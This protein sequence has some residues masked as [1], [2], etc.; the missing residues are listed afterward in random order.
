MLKKHINIISPVYLLLVFFLCLFFLGERASAKVCWASAVIEVSSEYAK[1]QYS[2]NQALGMP[3]VL[4]S[5]GKSPSSWMPDYR[6]S[7]RQHWIQ[8][9]FDTLIKAKQIVINEN[10]HPGGIIKICFFSETG[11]KYEIYN[12]TNPSFLTDAKDY[13][14]LTF[15]QTEYNIASVQIILKPNPIFDGQ[16]IDAVAISDSE[17]RIIPEIYPHITGTERYEV[18]NLGDKVNS[19]YPDLAPLIS[20]DGKTLYFTRDKH[21][22]NIGVDKRQDIWYSKKDASGSFTA[23][24]NIGY[25]IN[26]GANNFALSITPDGNKM[27][28][29]NVYLPDGSM[30]KGVSFTTKEGNEWLPPQKVNIKNFYNLNKATGGFFLSNSGKV[31]IMSIERSDGFGGLDLYVSFPLD[32]NNFTEPMNLGRLVNTASD[33]DSPFLASD[34]QTLYFSTSGIPGYGSNDMFI[35][36]RQ[37]SSWTNWD[38]PKN[39]G[40]GINTSGWDAYYTIPAS[41]DYAYFVSDKKSIGMDDIFRIKLPDWARPKPVLLVSGVVYN[42]KTHKPIGSKIIYETLPEGKEVGVAHSNNLTGEYQIVLPAGKKYGFLAQSDGF[43]A[44]N[45]HLDL[46]DVSLYGEITR[47]LFLIPIEIGQTIRLNNIFFDFDKFDLLPDSYIELNRLV[48]FL[49]SNSALQIEIH[50]H[51]DNFGSNSYNKS[52]SYNR[53]NAVAN[54]LISKNISSS[55]L[56]VKG[57]GEEKPVAKNDTDDNRKLNRRV[58]FVIAGKDNK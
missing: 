55:R 40:R 38:T 32:S 6:I 14:I 25:P 23:A 37:D 49:N 31:M 30:S 33:E 47:D 16:Q 57:F 44:V 51:T 19:E 4:P 36:R 52:L 35:T 42:K 41:G 11:E 9:A 22:E 7:T 29:G 54:Y 2:A 5:F 8:L 12:N 18:Q 34:E 28:V 39:M 15:P 13:F 48:A 17:E 20:P 10:L 46:T 50:G 3:S 27:L 45:E 58:E 43:I 1:L 53:A 56:K 21:P 24:L 26:T